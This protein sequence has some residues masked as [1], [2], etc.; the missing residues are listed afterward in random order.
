M[1]ASVAVSFSMI[2][3][4]SFMILD[5]DK[6]SDACPVMNILAPFTLLMVQ[7]LLKL[8]IVLRGLNMHIMRFASPSYVT[9]I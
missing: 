2:V 5:L 8:L 3:K 1:L 7:V 9:G 4:D 6:F